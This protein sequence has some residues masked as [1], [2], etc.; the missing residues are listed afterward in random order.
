MGHS[1]G[2]PIYVRNTTGMFGIDD[3]EKREIGER[4]RE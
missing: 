4:E 2:L 3:L 1:I